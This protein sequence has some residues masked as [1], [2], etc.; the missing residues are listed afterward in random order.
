MN[1]KKIDIK[2]ILESMTLEE[3]IGQLI[4]II[5]SFFNPKTTGEITGPLEDLGLKEKDIWQV[6]SVIGISGAKEAINIQKN[7]LEKSEKKIPLIF[8]ADIIHGYRTIF[9]IPLGIG[10]TW[11]KDLAKEVARVSAKEASAAGIH[12]TFSPMVD[13]VRDARWGRVMESTGEDP[14]LNS[15]FARAFVKG[16]QGD[17]IKKD[18]NIGACVKHFAAYGAPEGG[19]EYN[20]VDISEGMLRE[21]YFPSYKAAIEE[22]VKMVMTSFNPVNRIPS[23][24]NTWLMR[25]ILRNEWGFDGVTISDW[26]QLKN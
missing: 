14:Y 5:P 10:C 1:S 15:L 11:D 6:G 25:D 19:R 13:L 7:Y 23:S 2:K 26:G 16:Y 9:P 24:G 21:Y 17:D 4:Q 3:K 20:T 12:V 22:G 8:M 18:E